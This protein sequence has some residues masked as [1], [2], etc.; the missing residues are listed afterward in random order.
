MTSI[1]TFE[2]IRKLKLVLIIYLIASFSCLKLGKHHPYGN[3]AMTYIYSSDGFWKSLQHLDYTYEKYVASAN[4]PFSAAEFDKGIA[5]GQYLTCKDEEEHLFGDLNSDGILDSNLQSYYAFNTHNGR[6]GA[7]VN[8]ATISPANSF[9]YSTNYLGRILANIYGTDIP[10][11][12]ATYNDKIKWSILSGYNG[13]AYLY[14][15][16]VSLTT[17]SDY[18]L[19]GIYYLDSNQQPQALTIYNSLI[20]FLAPSYNANFSI[21]EYNYSNLL[22]N[23]D[24]ALTLIFISSF[25][26]TTRDD[27]ALQHSVSLRSILLTRQQQSTTVYSTSVVK[28]GWLNVDG[29]LA[30]TETALAIIALGIGADLT[31]E[32]LLPPFTSGG[33]SPNNVTRLQN[34]HRY[35]KILTDYWPTTNIG[36][37]PSVTLPLGIVNFE[38]YVRCAFLIID[39]DQ[40]YVKDSILGANTT[41]IESINSCN[42]NNPT[43]WFMVRKENSVISAYPGKMDLQ[44]WANHATVNDVDYLYFKIDFLSFST[45]NTTNTPCQAGSNFIFSNNSKTYN[46]TDLINPTIYDNQCVYSGYPTSLTDETGTQIYT[47][48]P[49]SSDQI[50]NRC[51]SCGSGKFFDTTQILDSNGN[52]TNQTYIGNRKQDW[53][54]ISSCASPKLIL[55]QTCVASCPNGYF[56]TG[57]TCS[58][59]AAGSYSDGTSCVTT[60]PSNKFTYK[61]SCIS[62]CPAFTYADNFKRCLNACSGMFFVWKNT[63][64]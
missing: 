8:H 7:N 55:G 26:Y 43:N 48:C 44:S 52:F 16:E 14:T 51:L 36:S 56:L 53:P 59:C 6:T 42:P 19:K 27:T 2:T 58:Q 32:I 17:A 64:S 1:Q 5:K 15:G 49:A 34:H 47:S 45:P 62:S 40:Y 50:G 29:V 37:G 18:A 23:Y 9:F 57:S 25:Y 24:L 4:H 3:N 39:I 21:M 41:G 60:C 38:M 61:L 12:L 13:P 28:T 33:A 54:C 30:F 63:C 20:T 46:P 35:H 10:F 31:Y 11:G 22:S